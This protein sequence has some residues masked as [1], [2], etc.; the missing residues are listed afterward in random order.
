[1]SQGVNE[2]SKKDMERLISANS[3]T[4]SFDKPKEG[5]KLKIFKYWTDFSQVYVSNIKQNFI[6]CDHC[7]IVLIYKTTTGS[8]CMKSHVQS[9]KAQSKKVNSCGEQPKIHTYCKNIPI[10]K[11]TIPK[12]IK[13]DITISCAEFAIEDCRPFELIKGPGFLQLA[14][15]LFNHGRNFSSRS[16]DIKDLVPD[17]TTVSLFKMQILDKDVFHQYLFALDQSMH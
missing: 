11:K 10:V 16:V 8:G 3:S 15:K 17:G 13:R 7:K 2:L 12:E 1:M 9:C 5:S 14:Q 4:V 6:V